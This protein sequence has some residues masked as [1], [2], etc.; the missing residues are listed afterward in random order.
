MNDYTP[1]TE[2]VRNV[3]DKNYRGFDRWLEQH[4]KEVASATEQRIIMLLEDEYADISEPKGSM[5]FS[6]SYLSGFDSAIA[7]IKGE[8][9]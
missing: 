7:L 1:T 9:K 6:G 2:E 3:Y 5:E 4:D 8:N